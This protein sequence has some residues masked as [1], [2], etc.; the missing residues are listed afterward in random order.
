MTSKLTRVNLRGPT[1]SLPA[2]P[3]PNVSRAVTSPTRVD[4]VT[5]AVHHVTNTCQR[6]IGESESDVNEHWCLIGM[7]RDI[8]VVN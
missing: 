2:K 1:R 3:H 7:S 6:S 5:R 4:H 8:G